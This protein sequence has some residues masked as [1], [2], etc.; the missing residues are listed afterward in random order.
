MTKTYSYKFSAQTASYDHSAINPC[1]EIGLFL[2]IKNA[3]ANIK[4]SGSN[5]GV[6]K[7]FLSQYFDVL[8]ISQEKICKKMLDVQ[9]KY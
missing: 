9:F 2:M 5:P 1:V 4:V 3:A 7:N 6:G 8:Q